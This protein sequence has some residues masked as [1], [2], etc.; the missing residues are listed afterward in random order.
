MVYQLYI[1]NI[2]A[3]ELTCQHLKGRATNV[4]LPMFVLLPVTIPPHIT[5]TITATTTIAAI[6]STA[7][8]I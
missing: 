5:T 7:T 8:N 1:N 4:F 6:T 3:S 2:S